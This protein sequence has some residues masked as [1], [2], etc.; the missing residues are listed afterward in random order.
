MGSNS[1]IFFAKCYRPFDT[2][3]STIV[4][5]THFTLN[6]PYFFFYCCVL[7]V[8]LYL[9]LPKSHASSGQK[10]KTEFP[11]F[12]LQKSASVQKLLEVEWRWFSVYHWLLLILVYF[13]LIPCY[14]PLLGKWKRSR[15]KTLCTNVKLWSKLKP[16]TAAQTWSWWDKLYQLTGVYSHL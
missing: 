7:L 6:F 16:A 9:C 10:S 14:R 13:L 8:N 2:L 4:Y 5:T 11:L 3:L 15:V 12:I 1:H